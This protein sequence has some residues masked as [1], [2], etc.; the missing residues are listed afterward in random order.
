MVYII[1]IILRFI[2]MNDFARFILYLFSVSS[3]SNPIELVLIIQLPFCINISN[4]FLAC[5]IYIR[6]VTIQIIT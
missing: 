4:F 1:Y 3:V 5:Y 2:F 6:L